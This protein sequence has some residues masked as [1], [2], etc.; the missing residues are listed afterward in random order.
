[1]K[2]LVIIQCVALLILL[3]WFV[4]SRIDYRKEKKKIDRTRRSKTLSEKDD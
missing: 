2:A 3:I 4:S 1:M